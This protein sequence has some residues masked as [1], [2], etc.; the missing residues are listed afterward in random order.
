MYGTKVLFGKALINGQRFM[1]IKPITYAS[2]TT[3]LRIK[4]LPVKINDQFIHQKFVFALYDMFL[5]IVLTGK[6]SEIH[7]LA[8]S[9]VFWQ[10]KLNV[11]YIHDFIL[12][13][14]SLL[15]IPVFIATFL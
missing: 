6:F 10:K 1:P 15:S 4:V 14:I 9:L 11:L 2:S 5:L 13:C 7:L 3:N 12:W 8:I